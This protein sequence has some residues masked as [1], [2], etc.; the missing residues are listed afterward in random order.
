MVSI[1]EA[2]QNN[3]SQALGPFTVNELKSNKQTKTGKLMKRYAISD[4]SGSTE[5]TMFEPAA[6]MDLPLGQPITLKGKI[7][8][9]EY[10]GSVSLQTGKVTLDGAVAQAPSEAPT[11]A[12]AQE[13]YQAPAQTYQ[14]PAA[15]SQ[16]PIKTLSPQ[17][18]AEAQASHFGR[19]YKL[20][21][22]P[23]I[24]NGC[25]PSSVGIA[26]ASM[27]GSASDWWFGAKYPGFDK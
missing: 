21:S 10:N 19:L 4:G 9:N 24:N 6:F 1:Q 7:Q 18:L 13:V 14:T 12:P 8:K 5:L 16:G 25:D 22:E 17:E 20:I 3:E 15:P 23:M 27:T 11:G 2:L 26:A